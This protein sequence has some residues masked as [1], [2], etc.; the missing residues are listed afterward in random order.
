ML[1]LA[2][3]AAGASRED[4]V[5]RVRAG[6]ELAAERGHSG[7]EL[8]A[9]IAL[10]ELGEDDG[11]LRRV[12]ARIGEGEATADVAAANALLHERTTR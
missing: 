3:L 7:L 9:A 6:A 8:R 1:G 4:A 11:R 2:E 10:A 5:E 12:A